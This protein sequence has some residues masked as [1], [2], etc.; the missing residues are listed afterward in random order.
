MRFKLRVK[1]DTSATRI[2]KASKD[3]NTLSGW[4]FVMEVEAWSVETMLEHLLL[5]Y[6]GFDDNAFSIT[7]SQV[8]KL[9]GIPLEGAPAY[10]AEVAKENATPFHII[11]F[12]SWNQ[13]AWLV[14][15]WNTL[16]E[17]AERECPDTLE[18]LEAQ[19]A[20]RK[21]KSRKQM[22]T[23]LSLIRK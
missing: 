23:A 7:Q 9:S 8:S 1:K 12:D 6:R 22:V 4:P 15:G 5:V 21:E 19:I 2:V 10:M 11:P 17:Y 16:M 20:E 13:M 18:E 14:I 3:A